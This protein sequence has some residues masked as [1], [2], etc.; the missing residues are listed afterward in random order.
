MVSHIFKFHPNPL[1]NDP[2]W[3]IFVICVWSHQLVLFGGVWAW[4]GHLPATVTMII[5]VLV[6]D[7]NLNLQLA[8][9]VTAA[10][11]LDWRI[12][13]SWGWMTCGGF[14]GITKIT[15]WRMNCF[16]KM[17]VWM[18]RVLVLYSITLFQKGHWFRYRR[19][20]EE[21]RVSSCQC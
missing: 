12:W 11:R 7:P 2:I 14:V 1:G 3:L 16:N 17:E 4:F 10:G 8:S 15:H 9:W 5:T 21:P 18:F 19:R 13:S 6:G 20:E